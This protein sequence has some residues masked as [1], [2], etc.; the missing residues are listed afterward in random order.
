MQIQQNIQLQKLNT[1]ATPAYAKWFAVVQQDQDILAALDFCEQQQCDYLVLGEGSNSLFISDLDVLVIANRIGGAGQIADLFADVNNQAINRIN[2]TQDYSDFQIGAGVNWHQLVEQSL[3]YGYYGLEHMALIP[4]LV[5]AAPIQNIGAY[6]CEVKDLLVSVRAFDTKQKKFIELDHSECQFA[7]RDS[8]FKHNPERYIITYVTLRLQKHSQEFSLDSMYPA[9]Q[10]V[11]SKH[12]TI[13]QFDIFQAVCEVRQ[14]KL[15]S[16]KDIP[17]SGSFFKN[18]I[19]STQQKVDLQ[20]QFPELV[21]YSVPEGAKL[22]AGWL[23][24]QAGLKGFFAENGVGCYEKQAL[25]VVNPDKAEGQAVLD[26][27]KYVQT[28]IYE[29]FGVM[30]EIEPRLYQSQ[31]NTLSCQS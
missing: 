23:I 16:P 2:D 24:E 30:L 26:F 1:M 19:V 9:L 7:Y 11:L 6:G 28:T 8:L 12:Q 13:N 17:N 5:G 14:S 10:D 15:P 20:K 27:S 4:G 22:A 18:P 25:V 29:K 3:Q 31:G 21:S